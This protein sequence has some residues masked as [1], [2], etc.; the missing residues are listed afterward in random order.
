MA[1][2]RVPSESGGWLSWLDRDTVLDVTVNLIPLVI[3]AFFAVLYTL[4]QP[5]EFDPA[6]FVIMH[7]LT[8]FPFLLLVILTYSPRKSSRV[9]SD[10]SKVADM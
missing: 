4:V 2:E 1:R 5:W 6:M 3:L 7:F 9:T 10:D 8:L